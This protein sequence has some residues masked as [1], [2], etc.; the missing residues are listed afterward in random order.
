[1]TLTLTLTTKDF[2]STKTAEV[3]HPKE[4]I[5]VLHALFTLYCDLEDERKAY[6]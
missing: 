4:L 5:Q 6:S 3:P 2:Q 1:M